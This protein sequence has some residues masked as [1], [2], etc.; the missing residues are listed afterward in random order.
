MGILLWEVTMRILRSET[1]VFC[2][3]RKDGEGNVIETLPDDMFF[4]VK[5]DH[6]QK[7]AL[8]SK[9]LLNGGISFDPET[10]AYTVTLLPGDTDGLPFGKYC[11]D[12]KRKLGND[13]KYILPKTELEIAAVVTHLAN[14]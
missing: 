12:I 11:F 9:T 10:F 14:E 6:H 2:F 13:E 3:K 8:I 5:K 7:E 4:T 1:T